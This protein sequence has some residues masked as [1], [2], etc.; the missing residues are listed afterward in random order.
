MATPQGA[1]L[2][3][4]HCFS[5]C[6]NLMMHWM[7]GIR[8]VA[9]CCAYVPGITR[10]DALLNPMPIHQ[11]IHVAGDIALQILRTYVRN[12]G[13]LQ[14]FPGDIY[15]P[16]NFFNQPTSGKRKVLQESKTRNS[17]APSK[18]LRAAV[19]ASPAPYL[20]R[21]SLQLTP[22]VGR[23]LPFDVFRWVADGSV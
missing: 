15:L 5:A 6:A 2:S 14:V 9:V 7:L 12:D 20:P 1:S 23:S 22:T 18:P 19:P 17:S 11:G 13:D 3:C 16:V 4:S 8:Y 21:L 10:K